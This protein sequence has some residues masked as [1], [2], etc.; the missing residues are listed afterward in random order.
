MEIRISVNDEFIEKL[1]EDTG[2]E[3]ATQLVS[4]ALSLLKYAV[5]ESKKGRYL[6]SAN[7]DGTNLKR[8]VMPSLE[9][10]LQEVI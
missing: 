1:R 5:S 7:E 6:I 8:I 4:E 10:S 3:K 2:I 9:H